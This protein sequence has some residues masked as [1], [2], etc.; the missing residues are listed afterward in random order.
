MKT[1]PDTQII[2]IHLNETLANDLDAL[3]AS[4]QISTSDY[5]KMVLEQWL[6]SDQSL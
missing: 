3:A 2:R 6:S 4:M 1:S 5:V